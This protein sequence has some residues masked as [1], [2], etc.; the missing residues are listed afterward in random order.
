MLLLVASAAAEAGGAER[1]TAAMPVVST[2][3]SWLVRMPAATKVSFR[4][5][6]NLD[7]AGGGPG[8]FLYPAPN[9]GGLLAAVLTHGLIMESVK[10]SEK[11]KLQ[12]A[13][14]KVLDPYRALLDTWHHEALWDGAQPHLASRAKNGASAEVASGTWTIESLP[15]FGMTQD[16]RGIVLDNALAF[17]A[18]GDAQRTAKQTTV[19]V[20]SEPVAVQDAEGHWSA[21]DARRLKEESAALLAVSIDLAVAE[22]TGRWIDVHVPQRT[23][24]YMEGGVE[25]MERAQALEETCAR[26]VIR[27][28]RGWLMSIPAKRAEP[29]PGT[30]SPEASS[31]APAS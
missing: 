25:R 17:I 16:R 20:V 13:A 7:A 18:P 28:L 27:T 23:W 11:A 21:D 9:V 14:D 6:H 29:C 26:V 4:G 12:D 19:R 31:S 5:L 10:A 8:G 1:E 3:A 24:R 2:D 15:V 22:A 30:P